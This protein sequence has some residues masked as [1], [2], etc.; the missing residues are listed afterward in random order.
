MGYREGLLSGVL[1]TAVLGGPWLAFAQ[2][3]AEGAAPLARVRTWAYQL[4]NINAAT[5]ARTSYD[6]LVVDGLSLTAAEVVRLKRKPDGSR[7]IVLV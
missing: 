6:L 3:P 7:R 4:Q 2:A 5:L 1:L